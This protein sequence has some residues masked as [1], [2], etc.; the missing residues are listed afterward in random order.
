MRDIAKMFNLVTIGTMALDIILVLMGIFLLVSGAYAIIKYII[1]PRGIFKLEL[2]YGILSVIAGALAIFKP[3]DVINFITI[4][5]GIWLVINSVV[6][7]VVALEIRKH[8]DAWIFDLTVAILTLVLGVLLLVN[9]FENFV[10]LSVY[11]GVMMVVY[12]AMDLVEQSFISNRAKTL[13]IM[14]K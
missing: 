12:G 7:V 3:F 10:V 8:S 14:F 2:I 11:A 6:K 5:V 9:P 1:N 4:L 13:L